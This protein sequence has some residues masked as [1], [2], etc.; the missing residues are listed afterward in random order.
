MKRLFR[1][2]PKL[3]EDLEKRLCQNELSSTCYLFTFRSN[4]Q[5][6][7]YC[8]ECKKTVS[9]AQKRT[10]TYDE[11]QNRQKKHNET[12]FCPECKARVTF[13]DSGRG[14]NK[15]WDYAHFII[16][17]RAGKMLVLRFFDVTRSLRHFSLDHIIKD[18]GD[19]E[20]E[21]H[22]EHRLFLDPANRKA[23]QF[24]QQ[25][26]YFG[27][28]RYAK[29]YGF[30]AGDGYPKTGWQ[31]RQRIKTDFSKYGFCSIYGLDDK[32]LEKTG[33]RYCPID[34]YDKV[35]GANKNYIEFL[36]KYTL[37][38]NA[39]EYM[40]KCGFPELFSRLMS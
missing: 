22:E 36:L 16:A 33:F 32:L 15:L 38:P 31:K 5:R 23:Y 40:M 17:Q 24:T 30:E 11:V 6:Y 12:G 37:Y 3:P 21:F 20:L 35:S 19:G 13:K 27:N 4:G 7:G 29:L 34:L 26:E 1:L 14:K 2:V 10:E 8:T 28:N 9:L 18:C 25:W 39:V